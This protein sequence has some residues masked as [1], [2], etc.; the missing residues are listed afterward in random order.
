[1]TETTRR[2][3]ILLTLD[4]RLNSLTRHMDVLKEL[5]ALV[6]LEAEQDVLIRQTLQKAISDSV[7]FQLF[8]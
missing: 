5:L 4:I 8:H 3:D 6:S 2:P 7:L 1:M